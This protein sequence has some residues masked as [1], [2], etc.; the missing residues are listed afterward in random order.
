MPTDSTERAVGVVLFPKK[1]GYE[2]DSDE[3]LF[4]K[5]RIKRDSQLID[6]LYGQLKNNHINRTIGLTDGI[7][8]YDDT[9]WTNNKG[10]LHEF[11]YLGI[12]NGSITPF[13]K[14]EIKESAILAKGVIPTLSPNDP[15]FAE[16]YESYKA[17]IEKMKE[18]EK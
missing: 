4:D 14:S 1:L 5:D 16:W 18:E 13:V 8:K 11:L 9:I 17:E 7:K 3:L 12:A 2:K 10:I 15:N 6:F